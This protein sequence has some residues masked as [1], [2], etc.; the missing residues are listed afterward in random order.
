MFKNLALVLLTLLLVGLLFNKPCNANKLRTNKRYP[1]YMVVDSSEH[2]H[3]DALVLL[4]G[5]EIGVLNE[6]DTSGNKQVLNLGIYDG[7]KLP[8]GAYAAYFKSILGVSY[9]SFTFPESSTIYKYVSPG[10]TLSWSLISRVA[11]LDTVSAKVVLKL[12]KEVISEVDSSLN[13]K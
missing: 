1:L 6:I 13:K 2:V 9:L 8:Y 10:D 3:Y 7:A 12:V 5:K 11:A 4:N